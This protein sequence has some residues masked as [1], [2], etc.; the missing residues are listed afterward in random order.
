M[1]VV[2]ASKNVHKI[3]EFREILQHIKNLDLTSLL[4][5]PDYEAPEE[6]ADTLEEN[7]KVKAEHAAKVLKKHVLADD[8]GLFVVTLGGAPGVISKRYSGD[9]AT[10]AENR[11]KLLK[12]MTGKEG[13]DRCA[14]YECCIFLAN[15]DGIIKH[16][17][18]ICEGVITEEERG[19][20]GFGY[21]P[22]FQKHDYD[23]TFAELEESTKNRISHRM[24]AVQKILPTLESL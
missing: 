22:L 5:Y 20:N 4:D 15:P 11:A 14:Y 21:D 10:D 13:L 7:A 16:V 9:D 6:K 3:R 19:R 18:G 24:K 2:I 1:E 17:K 23:K 12:E 8:S